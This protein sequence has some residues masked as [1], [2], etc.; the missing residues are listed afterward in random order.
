MTDPVS[1]VAA[2]TAYLGMIIKRHRSV[3][4]GLA[5]YGEHLPYARTILRS[6]EALIKN[7]KADPIKLL[8]QQ[9]GK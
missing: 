2:G 9:I 7:P 3:L 6:G 4:K 5:S 1:N 8:Q